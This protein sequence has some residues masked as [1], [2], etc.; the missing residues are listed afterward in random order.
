M[1]VLLHLFFLTDF[2]LW[3]F[4]KI[5]PDRKIF[6]VFDFLNS[7][8]G[9]NW[10]SMASPLWKDGNRYYFN[11]YPLLIV[12]I[13]PLILCIWLTIRLVRFFNISTQDIGFKF[14]CGDKSIFI[15]C[16]IFLISLTTFLMIYTAVLNLMAF[17]WGGRVEFHSLNS[18]PIRFNALIHPFPEEILYR[19][20]FFT[21][22]L[23]HFPKTVV[24]LL[25]SVFFGLMHV[26]IQDIFFIVSSLLIGAYLGWIY[27]R[28]RSLVLPTLVHVAAN[29]IFN[30][31]GHLHFHAG[32]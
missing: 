7:L 13:V 22:F 32:R 9:G 1:C 15:S 25:S 20:I 18:D 12:N 26:F 21:I 27:L 5:Y 19:G 30:F 31:V 24:W 29:F 3:F 28:T 23:R 6:A 4:W 10:F 17:L 8:P 16:L 14:S 2:L 11:L